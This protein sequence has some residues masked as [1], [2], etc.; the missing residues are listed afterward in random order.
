MYLKETD[1]IEPP[2]GGWPNL[3]ANL[4]S[5]S[6]TDEVISL[7]YHLPYIRKPSDDRDKAHGAPGCYLADWQKLGSSVSNGGTTREI[8]KL[9]SEGS[10]IH[11]E[12]PPPHVISLTAGGRYN[13]VFLLDIKLGV[14]HWY[15]CP[16][17]IRYEPSREPIEDD[18]YDY[19]P[20]KEAEW[21][22]EGEYWAIPD[23]SSGCSRINSGS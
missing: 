21:R 12:M 14:V 9:V 17:E 8:L 20:E 15:E 13:P 16:S 10:S 5:L 2:E 4:Q 22:A 3:S 19:A 18:P 7:L 1:V 6:K 23:F 11:E